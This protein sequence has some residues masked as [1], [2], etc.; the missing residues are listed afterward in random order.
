[1][2]FGPIKTEGQLDLQALHR[3]RERLV[4][5]QTS[6]VNQIRAFERSCW[7]AASARERAGQPA[8]INAGDSER[9]EFSASVRDDR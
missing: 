6:V 3:V 1:M 9:G 2:R 5:R 7:S 8:P 4:S